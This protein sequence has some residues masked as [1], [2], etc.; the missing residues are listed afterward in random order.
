MVKA[1]SK[2]DL[3]FIGIRWI[4]FH[5]TKKGIFVLTN[6][7]YFIFIMCPIEC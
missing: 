3:K 6:C 4:L 1:I 5:Y 2:I 7:D